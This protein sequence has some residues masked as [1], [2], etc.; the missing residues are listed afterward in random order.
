[1]VNGQQS[2]PKTQIQAARPSLRFEPSAVLPASKLKIADIERRVIPIQKVHTYGK[3]AAK[4]AN[5]EDSQDRPVH[6]NL[7]LS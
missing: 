4:M 7:V 2:P 5:C 1:M 3:P 6:S